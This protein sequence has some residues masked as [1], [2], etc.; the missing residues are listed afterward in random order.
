M[1]KQ[2]WLYDDSVFWKVK[3]SISQLWVSELNRK[4]LRAKT[5]VVVLYLVFTLC[6]SGGIL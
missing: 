1:V 3:N 4:R 2:K 5:K 6:L